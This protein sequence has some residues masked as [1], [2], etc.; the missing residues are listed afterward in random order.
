MSSVA[1]E[2][3]VDEHISGFKLFG[4]LH[5]FLIL[6]VFFGLFLI[7]H[8]RNDIAHI[9]RK[10]MVRYLLC[11]ILLSNML[12]YYGEL[13]YYG[14]YTWKTHLPLHFCYISGFSFMYYLLT[15]KRKVYHIIYFFSFL[16]PLPAIL[17]PKMVSSFDSFIFYQWI[18]SHHVFLLGSFFIYYMDQFHLEHKDVFHT[19]LSA[20]L[21]FIVMSVFNQIFNTNYIFSSGIPEYMFRLY[22]ILEYF[23]YPFLLIEVLGI[24]VLGIAY[25]PVLLNKREN[26]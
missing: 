3:F 10:K 24:V 6:V 25:I 8:Y 21:I 22:P 14:N 11:L 16:G 26:N 20:Q 17:W 19:F 5:L 4:S 2:F 7:Y 15:E 18:I 1:R 9:K 13:I 23:N 12:I